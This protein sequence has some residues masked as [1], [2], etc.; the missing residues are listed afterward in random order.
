MTETTPTALTAL[1]GEPIPYVV[2]QGGGRA[3]LLI[4]QV[5]RC[6]AGAEETG[7]RGARGPADSPAL[8]RRGI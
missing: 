2:T 6:L 3:H 1:P 7:A 8:P 4:D 5:G